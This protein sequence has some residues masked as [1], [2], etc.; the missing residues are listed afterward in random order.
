VSTI[1]LVRGDARRLSGDPAKEFQRASG[2]SAEIL[3]PIT[4]DFPDPVIGFLRWRAA[5]WAR[6]M[7][8]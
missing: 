5:A 8:N 2:E 6:S 4:G 1:D 3:R 7:K